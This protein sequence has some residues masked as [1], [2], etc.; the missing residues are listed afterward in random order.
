MKKWPTTKILIGF[1]CILILLGA[2]PLA[3]EFWEASQSRPLSMPLPLQRGEY[4]SPYFRTYL[5]ST[6]QID[7]DSLPFERT[8]L[9][10]DWTIIDDRGTVILQGNFA[11][12]EGGLRMGPGNSH[13]FRGNN[14]GLGVYRP[15][16]GLRQRII[17]RV[18]KDVQ[19]S[20]LRA[21]LEI[22]QPEIT[23]DLSYGIFPLLGWAVLIGGAGGVLLLSLLIK[24]LARKNSH[25]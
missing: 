10:L 4:T 18:H 19:A 1:A 22:G 17:A 5:F 16:F 8:P 14:V 9:D 11:D 12:P 2:G 6:Y 23:L 13:E 24:Y 25:V 20:N 15:R 7:I 21:I 3:F